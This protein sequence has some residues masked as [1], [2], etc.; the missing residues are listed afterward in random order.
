VLQVWNI[1]R[2]SFCLEA[3]RCGPNFLVAILASA[4]IACCP[5]LHAFII[6][7]KYFV[8]PLL[9]LL[10]HAA[11]SG[12]LGPQGCKERYDLPVPLWLSGVSMS[13]LCL[14]DSSRSLSENK[15]IHLHLHWQ[16][17]HIKKWSR[18][19]LNPSKRLQLRSFRSLETR[20]PCLC[21]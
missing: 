14:F 17:M 20:V 2:T 6:V 10:L 15:G 4:P 1:S 9:P 8:G 5:R 11:A 13:C 18:I 12:P 16:A 7:Y 21:H 19:C 3:H